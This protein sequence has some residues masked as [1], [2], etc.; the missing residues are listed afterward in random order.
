M[1]W[2]DLRDAGLRNPDEGH[3]TVPGLPRVGAGRYPARD[4]D[5]VPGVRRGVQ[6]RGMHADSRESACARGA[7]EVAD[8]VEDIRSGLGACSL[9]LAGS[10]AATMR[11][12]HL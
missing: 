2:M 1:C 5:N 8:P 11:P 10:T 12:G 3:S 7:A 4:L 6:I 9:R